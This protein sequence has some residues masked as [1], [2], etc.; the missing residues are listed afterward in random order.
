MDKLH[1][2]HLIITGVSCSSTSY[3]TP[4]QLFLSYSSC[5]GF[6]ASQSEFSKTTVSSMCMDRTPR[7][8]PLGAAFIS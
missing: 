7:S 8:I 4:I 6:S 2:A 5:Q 3:C 1:T